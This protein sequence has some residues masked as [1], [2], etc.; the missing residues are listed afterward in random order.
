MSH[1]YNIFPHYVII[2]DRHISDTGRDVS[3]ISFVL[4]D[5]SKLFY[6]FDAFGTTVN[7][8]SVLRQIIEARNLNRE[9]SVG[10]HPVIAYYT[11]KAEIFSS[12]TVVGRISAYHAP[13]FNMGSPDGVHI[14]NKIFVNI[15]F[16]EAIT[17]S[18]AISRMCKPL[19]FFELIVGRAQNL[20]EV[21][22]HSG[23]DQKRETSKVYISLYPIHERSDGSF[24]PSFRD[25]L[26]DAVRE[27]DGFASVLAAWLER[28]MIW[29]AA[30]ERF[31]KGWKKQREY[32]A[33]RI[34][35]AANM[36]DLLPEAE[37]PDNETLPENLDFAV[38]EAKRIFQDL[39]KS[40]DRDSVLST[41]GRVGK[42]TLKRK[43][44]HRVQVLID[45]IGTQIP[46]ICM[47]IDEAVNCRNKYV[48]G[49][50][51]P[52]I[53]YDKHILVM[54]FLT[55]TLEF[56]FSSS[57][58]VDMGWNIAE[59]SKTSKNTNHPFGIYLTTYLENLG[60]LKKISTKN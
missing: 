51:S 20:V 42:S 5:A 33:D 34:I 45:K 56:V 31:S 40:A 57:D 7:Q 16:D 2:G 25:V 4:D 29:Q 17:F 38:G 15:R 43:I 11:G 22:I 19:R 44:R 24:G 13:S 39:P 53:D 37:F 46:E 1:Y 26:I 32:D 36:F 21:N 58:L 50:S 27:P 18:D 47:V 12:N 35:R 6:D 30:R 49:N 14:Q 60:E 23:T 59:W 55:N 52:A 41:L 9:I 8:Q 10:S 28:D 48:H 3:E 54:A